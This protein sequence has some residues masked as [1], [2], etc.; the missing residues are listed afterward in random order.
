MLLDSC[1]RCS[2]VS[3]ASEGASEDYEVHKG[4]VQNLSPGTKLRPCFHHWMVRLTTL[5]R[6][7]HKQ[8]NGRRCRRSVVLDYIANGGR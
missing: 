1:L 5:P 3:F 8:F 4:K 2:I 6:F 7:C